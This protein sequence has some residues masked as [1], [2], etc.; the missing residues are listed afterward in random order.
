MK[1][2][3]PHITVPCGLACNFTCWVV[4]LELH[5]KLMGF[6]YEQASKRLET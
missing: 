3:Y 1:V 5:M 6:A 2:V 4:I